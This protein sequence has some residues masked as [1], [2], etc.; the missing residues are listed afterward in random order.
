MTQW[1]ELVEA[2]EGKAL[3]RL[4]GRVEWW[5]S[6]GEAFKVSAPAINVYRLET[7]GDGKRFQGPIHL[8][9]SVSKVKEDPDGR[10]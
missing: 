1:I 2:K 6:P 10:R 4:N 7:D 8:P 3:L 9:S 5:M